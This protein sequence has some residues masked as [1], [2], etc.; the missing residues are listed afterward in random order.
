M[1]L[2]K[3]IFLFT[4]LIISLSIGGI[5]IIGAIVTVDEQKNKAI[6]HMSLENL[7][8]T[9]RA[10]SI[11]QKNVSDIQIF[12][13]YYN[14]IHNI[15]ILTSGY[16][17]QS[18]DYADATIMLTTQLGALESDQTLLDFRLVDVNGIIIYSLN[19]PFDVGR[20]GTVFIDNVEEYHVSDIFP[21]YH[22]PTKLAVLF[23]SPVYDASNEKIGYVDVIYDVSELFSEFYHIHTHD[24]I[25]ANVVLVERN[26][27]VYEKI[28]FL[29]NTLKST[30]ISPDMYPLEYFAS[31]EGASGNTELIFDD[32]KHLVVFDHI[33]G[34]NLG[35]VS[36]IPTSVAYQSLMAIMYIAGPIQI[37][38]TVSAIIMSLFMAKTITNPLKSI[39]RKLV[40]FTDTTADE[41]LVLSKPSSDELESL[42]KNVDDMADIIIHHVDEVSTLNKILDKS[43]LISK[44][45][46][47][48][49]ITSVNQMFCD[50]SKYTEDELIGQYHNIINSGYH[51]RSFFS[52]MW[53]TITNGFIWIGEIKNRA[54]DGSTYWVYTIISPNKTRGNDGYISIR[55]DIS[56]QKELEEQLIEADKNKT[57]FAAVMAHEL[58]SPLS[59]TMLNCEI[60]MGMSNIDPTTREIVEDIYKSMSLLNLL[61]QDTFDVQKLALKQLMIHPQKIQLSEFFTDVKKNVSPFLEDKKL[62]LIVRYDDSEIFIDPVR[63]HQVFLNLIRNSVDFSKNNQKIEIGC[64]D[65][66]SEWEFFVQDY[67]S[68]IPMEKQS[69][70]FKEFYQIDSSM[71]R[72]HGGTGL[73]LSVCKG[74]VEAHGGRIWFK[75]AYGEGTT[76]FFTIPKPDKTD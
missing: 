71:T 27:H 42:S 24:I 12:S 16:N 39:Q 48:G 15:P 55:M 51:P 74:I 69:H 36:Q 1:N 33:P 66:S 70:V 45:D 30:V 54:K 9:E 18:Q 63:I 44:T 26:N 43:Y 76:F 53:N 32:E 22:D 62:E 52:D 72:K 40:Q 37:A 50:V 38:I 65:K 20:S 17:T 3:K 49:K 41:K 10:E 59:A 4:L 61:I 58:R 64:I 29:N 5:T 47:N 7:K 19:N 25:D 11:F 2:S 34:W 60:L 46:L 68:G 31:V 75:S 21:Y 57:E 56:K 8:K 13:N 23:S 28:T 14:V 73:G 6:E 35:I 67:G